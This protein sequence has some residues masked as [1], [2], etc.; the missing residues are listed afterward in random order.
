M[1]SLGQAL[2]RGPA[3][4]GA[5]CGCMNPAMLQRLEAL[6][7]EIKGRWKALLRDEPVLTPLG[8][9]D[10]LVFLMDATLTQLFAALNAPSEEKWLRS[11]PPIIATLHAYCLCGL[12]PVSKYFAAGEAAL[13]AATGPLPAEETGDLLARYR[14]LAQQEFAAVCQAC[15]H[16]DPPH[17]RRLAGPGPCLEEAGPDDSRPAPM[18]KA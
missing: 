3:A 12:D 8:R 16:P 2:R 5:Q 11:C 1:R 6:N 15:R 14:S 7:P 13:R 4:A 10:T 18:C 9:P 17:C